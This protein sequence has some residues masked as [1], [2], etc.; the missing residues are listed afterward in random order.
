MMSV[1]TMHRTGK[2]AIAATALLFIAGCAGGG[3]TVDIT[4]QNIAFN[5]AQITVPDGETVKFKL[6]NKDQVEHNLTIEQLQVDQDV[7]A[8]ETATVKTKSK[9]P[10]GTYQFFCEYHPQ[11]MKGTL[12]VS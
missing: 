7:E 2:T 5:P 11:Q 9:V 6:D 1:M 12:T 8:G 3:D 4:T 10:A